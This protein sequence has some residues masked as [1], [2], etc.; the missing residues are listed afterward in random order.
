MGST[1][2]QIISQAY[3]RHNLNEVTTFSTT[4]EFPYKLAL[5]VLNETI[6]RLNRLGDFRFSEAKTAIPYTPATAT[7]SFATL[8]IDSNRIRVLR[9]ELADHQ[10]DLKQVSWHDFQR[11]Y[12]TSPIQTAEPNTWA[13]YGDSLTL[14]SYPDQD[15]Q[16]YA[17]HYR[18]IALVTAPTDTFIIPEQD[19]DMLIDAC[20]Q[21]LGH[22]TGR[23]D[24]GT[25]LAAIVAL[26]NPFLVEENKDT[27]LPRQ[28]P[29]AF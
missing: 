15:Y 26:A 9:K 3:R 14:A 8:G 20:Y 6:R 16:I 27:G 21:I 23:W 13:K 1:A 29:A 28:M 2:V 19:E 17:Y 22:Y 25:A 11:R 10:Q 12:R 4:Q 18:N 7:Y 5:D 24:F